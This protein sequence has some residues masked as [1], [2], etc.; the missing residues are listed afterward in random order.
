MDHKLYI[1]GNGFDIHHGIPS[2]YSEFGRYLEAY[3]RDTADLVK[4][5][6]WVDKDFWSE[7]EARLA[8]F[9]ANRLVNE[10]SDFL[11]P[12]SAEDWSDAYHHDY[13][14]EINRVVE[15]LSVTLRVR[16]GAWVRQ[17]PIPDPSS[18]RC[19]LLPIDPGA[20]F[21]NFNYTPSLQRLYGVSNSH[22]KH[23]HGAA[24]D[25]TE[26]LILG[27]GWRST[28]RDS[29]NYGLDPEAVDSRVIE[30][31][32]AID[33]YFKKTFKPT[34]QIIR[35]SQFFF[36]TLCDVQEIIV[37]G[38]SLAP[39]DLPYFREVIR[40]IDPAKV[41]WRVSYYDDLDSTRAKFSQLG[42]PAA[43]VEFGRLA[44]F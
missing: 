39:I 5:S 43:C 28:A 10:T 20:T 18:I 30:G 27:H 42:V 35:D 9:D 33:Q 19:I 1:V 11:V 32:E 4:R 26:D 3:D 7:F 16:F 37:M 22:V 41:S 21:L 40:H 2:K 24:I 23:I 31:N 29:F 13:Q 25:P 34:D 14:Y 38:H 8:S 36:E 6:F 44:D 12:Y 17:L 15:A